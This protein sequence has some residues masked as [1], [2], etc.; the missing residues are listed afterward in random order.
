M[1]WKLALLLCLLSAVSSAQKT[2]QPATVWQYSVP[3]EPGTERRAYLW[4]PPQC[5]HVRGVLIGL[6][7]MLERPM[8]ED[9]AIRGAVADSGMA[10]V[11]ISPGAWPGKLVPPVQPDLG[12]SPK[13]DAIAGVQ[14]V[15]TALAR[16]SGYGEI[17]FA[18]LLVTG[19]SAAGPF[20]WG[21]ASA[22]PGRVFAALPY[23]N[24][25]YPQYAPVGVPTLY[26]SQEWAEWGRQWGEV[27]RNE[28]AATTALR[29]QEPRTMLGDFADLGA[30]HFDWNHESAGVPALFLRKAA[31]SRLPADASESGPVALRPVSLESGVLVDPAT[32]GTA[33]FKAIPYKDWKGDPAT[34]FWYFDREMAQAVDSS[35]AAGLNKKPQA[36]DF[37][38]DG[39]D[40][41]LA[42]NGFVAIRPSFLPDGVTFQVH[43]E[44]LARSPSPNLYNG[45][46]LG[47]ADSSI[48]YRVSSGALEQ[49]GPD[50]FRVAARSGGLTRQGM[51]WEPWIMAVQPGDAVYRA[52]DKPAHIL[53]DIHNAKGSP[54]TID[55]PRIAN[56]PHA[57]DGLTVDAPATSS[58]GLPVELYIESGPAIVEGGKI[59]LLQ[60]P[61]R[62]R[63]PVH[64][65]VS[66]FQW[67]RVGDR[68][69]QT[70]GPVTQEFEVGR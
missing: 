58:S 53:I 37:V 59:R 2:P 69:V 43:A 24:A 23:K 22:L 66:A 3:L 12:F 8:F 16:E 39:K 50:S 35:M 1:R 31:A 67:G 7:N 44:P 17:E 41:P 28:F 56:V 14:H 30:G 9:P 4:I 57:R 54:Q 21:M 47:H 48:V 29:R 64:V 45:A 5:T 19:H 26:V 32:L 52:T 68:P 62:S 27:W 10:I 20:A 15:L 42:D 55:F 13:D 51:P 49:V 63:Y 36:I 6:Q 25:I 70:A 65:I 60:P 40:A 18:P 61:P 11:W 34:G 38:V 46:A 33:K